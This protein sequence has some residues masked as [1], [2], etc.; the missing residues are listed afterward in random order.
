LGVAI[1]MEDGDGARGRN[2]GV[3]ETLWQLGALDAEAMAALSRY[4]SGPTKNH[5]GLIV[6]EMRSCFQLTP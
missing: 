1:K 5:R 6:G 4:A 2:A 3:V